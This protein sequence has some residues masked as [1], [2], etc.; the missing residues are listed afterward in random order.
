MFDLFV[1]LGF[2]VS[3]LVVCLVRYC[4]AVCDIAY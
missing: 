4:F 3:D 1:W 2:V